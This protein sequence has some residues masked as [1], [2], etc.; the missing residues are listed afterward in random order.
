MIYSTLSVELTLAWN[1]VDGIYEI[2][3]TGQFIPFLIGV[4]GLGR[5]LVSAFV[6]HPV[7]S[8]VSTTLTQDR[9]LVS[10]NNSIERH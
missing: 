2:S 3:S 4:L 5:A 7:P 6:T 10:A 9:E 8:R 1:N